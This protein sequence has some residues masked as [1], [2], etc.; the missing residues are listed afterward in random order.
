V[1]VLN[2]KDCNKAAMLLNNALNN[3]FC[4]TEQLMPYFIGLGESCLVTTAD[5]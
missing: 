2:S 4:V 1:W 3:A 5:V